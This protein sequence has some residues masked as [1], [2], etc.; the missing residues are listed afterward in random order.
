MLTAL[1]IH[2]NV[3]VSAYEEEKGGT[4]VCPACRAHLT[5]KK[6]S[7]N[8]H[9]FAHR[10]PVTCIYGVGESEEHRACKIELYESLRNHPRVRDLRIER[11]LGT[12][13][14]DV[15]GY[16]DGYPV[17][18]EVQISALS[19]ETITYR[20]VE[21]AK[22]GI[23]VLWL[24]P[25]RVSLD[26]LSCN[27]RLWEKWV[28]ATYFGRVYYH[29]PGSGPVLTPVHFD[30]AFSWVEETEWY[31]P[32]GIQESGGGY[33]R[34]LKRTKTPKAAPPVHLVDFQVRHRSAWQSKTLAVPKC[35]L[36]QDTRPGWWLKSETKSSSSS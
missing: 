5:I 13:R 22:Q 16:F 2:D 20:T 24:S 3:Q 17:A 32:G 35:I 15:S 23:A 10:P 4:W 14:P 1:R 33:Y 8:I 11:A 12:V 34:P 9:H 6:G 31:G 19:L 25:W 36:F 26:D 29:K 7:R 28:H 30:E 18:I 27:V 21:F